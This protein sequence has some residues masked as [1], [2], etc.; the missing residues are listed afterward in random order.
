MK[1]INR[2][3][4]AAGARMAGFSLV[5]L[6][7]ALALGLLVLGA[8]FV[9]FR[10]NQNSF[11]ASEG[12][13]RIQESARVAFELMS[14][15]IRSAGGSA[16]SSASIVE[17][18][19]TQSIAFRD[20]PLTGSATQ[21]TIVSG[22]DSAYRVTGSS[23]SSITLDSAQVSDATEMFKVGDWLLLC[24]ARKSFVVRATGVTSST[25]SFNALPE[26]YSP[27][28]DE[29]APPSSVVVARLRDIRWY[30]ADN[31]RGGKSLYVSRFG[32]TGEEVTDGVQSV[33]FSYLQS[34]G[35]S[36]TA[37][38]GDWL[39]V[40]AVRSDLV[41]TG[42]DVDGKALVRRASNVTNLRSRTL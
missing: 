5:E 14:Q 29:H 42:R 36:Y 35:T 32:G 2:P 12:I 16:C 20:T 15:D 24:N 3:G 31:S 13:H 30:V 7:I 38:P 27:G 10:S 37:T 34:G 23:S 41:L 39:S 18:S 22:E 19:D 40:I 17:T 26:G 8:A 6:M 25:I 11:R 21:L 9:V 28:T 33:A 1:T 4:L